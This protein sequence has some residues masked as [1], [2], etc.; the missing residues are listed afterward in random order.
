MRVPFEPNIRDKVDSYARCDLRSRQWHTDYFD[1]IEDPALRSRLGEEFFTA[2]YLYKVLEGLA[3]D[4]ELQ[5]AQVR[6][7]VL[8]YASIY[9][10]AIHHLLFDLLPDRAPVQAL[11]EI[12]TLKRYSIPSDKQATLESF[13]HDG[14]QIIPAY[15]GTSRVNVAKIRFDDK[16]FCA[17]DLGLLEPWLC[18]ELISIYE[19]RNAIHLHAEIRKGV[20]WGLELAINAYRRHEPF[21]E[22]VVTGLAAIRK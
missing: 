14:R 18:N 9:E 10:A 20:T 19:V 21:R 11:S 13:V 16:A 4:G 17:R 1:F 2:R 22:Q 3:A 6:L 12:T 15:E 8:Q 7:Q 5:V